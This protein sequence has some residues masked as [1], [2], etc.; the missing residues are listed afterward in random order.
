MRNGIIASFYKGVPLIP[1]YDEGGNFAGDKGA[2]VGAN[3][4][5]AELERNKHDYGRRFRMI[6]KRIWRN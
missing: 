3:G 2:Q 4:P 5:F 1:L 6:G